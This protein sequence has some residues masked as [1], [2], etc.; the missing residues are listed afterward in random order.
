MRSVA[1]A[2]TALCCA[3]LTISA[4]TAAGSGSGSKMSANAGTT[5]DKKIGIPVLGTSYPRM[6]D[7]AECREGIAVLLGTEAGKKAMD[8]IISKIKPYSERHVSDPEWIVSRLQMYWDSH[9]DEIYVKGEELDHVSGHAPVP[10]VRFTASRGTQTNYRR[11]RLED[12][13]PYQDSLGMWMHN[14]TKPGEPLEWAD[15]RKTGR[16]VESINLEIMNLARDAAFLYWWSGERTYAQFAADIFDTY[17]T[18]L[19]YREVP[20]DLNHGHQQTLLGLTSFEVIHED[21]AIP[22]AECYDFLHGYLAGEKPE[23]ITIYED[24]FRKWAD[25]IIAGGVPHNNWNLIQAQFVLR[26]ALVLSP[27]SSYEDGR[28]REWF[29]N[30]ILNEDSIRQWSP[31]KLIDYGFDAGTGLWKESPG[32]SMMV[33]TEWGSFIRLLDT[34]LG[35]DLVEA[36]PVLAE[37]VRNIPQYLFP[38]GIICGWG[39]THCGPLNTSFIPPMIENAAI[40]GKASE[41]EYFTAMYKCF[42]PGADSGSPEKMSLPAKVSTFTSMRPP[43]T[44]PD[45]PAGKIEDYVSPVFW[46]EEVS[47]FA[48][49]TGMDPE[50]SLMISI[51]GSMGN[52]MHA[53]GISMELYGKGYIMA[54]DAGRGSGYSTLDYSEYY[55]QFPAHN[56]VCVDGVSSYPVMQSRHAFSLNGCYPE[57]EKKEGIYPGVMFGD[58]SFIEPETYSDQRRQVLIIN[59]DQDN[60]YYIDIFRSARKDGKDR[61]HDYFYHNIGQE[62][63][64]SVPTKPTEELSFAGAHLSAYSYLWNKSAAETGNDIEGVFTMHCDD[65]SSAGMKMWMKGSQD[66]KVFKAYAPYIDGLSRMKMPYDIK[67]SPC[68]TFVARQ[69]GNAWEKPF[70]A[71]FEPFSSGAPGMVESVVYPDC[72]TGSDAEGIS[73]VRKDGRKD[74]IVSSDRMQESVCDGF[75]CEAV[76]A[77]CSRGKEGDLQIFMHNGISAVSG[78]I[79]IECEEPATAAVTVSDG[80]I[81][82]MSDRPCTVKA[83][84]RK[85][86]LPASDFQKIISRLRD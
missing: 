10:T 85:Y 55:S 61:F 66:R 42:V 54:P 19:Y 20:V 46:S 51:A 44:D 32:Y 33:L 73:V 7:D 75:A 26:I 57:P 22:A 6:V 16:N 4:S 1:A 34:V 2:A 47:W 52:H 81:R 8:G 72:G 45:I 83:G 80:E 63:G 13:R 86:R 29:L 31:G 3:C 23:K 74:I 59:T 58:F 82:Y 17:M 53:N 5:V 21:I 60:G 39:D 25:C 38:N 9:A 68:Q 18:G 67:S 35:V 70:V 11:P 14:K 50:N 40:H 71:L 79:S 69:Y 27:D 36:Y 64:L 28:G 62:F 78:D 84:K 65:G 15:P 41:K 76:L 30:E 77:V 43:Q 24:T 37:A 49:R 56:T 48:A 12:I